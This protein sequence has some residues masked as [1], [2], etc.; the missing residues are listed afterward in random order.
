[1]QH[2]GLPVDGSLQVALALLVTA[3]GPAVKPAWPFQRSGPG[4]LGQASVQPAVEV[5]V[6]A[7]VTGPGSLGMAATIE[8]TYRIGV[9]LGDIA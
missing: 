8:F 3:P 1:M 4:S 6:E 5:P 2:A 7:L 9:G